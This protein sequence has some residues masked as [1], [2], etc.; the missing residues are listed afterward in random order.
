MP[1]SLAFRPKRKTPLVYQI[2]R[3]LSSHP[4][5]GT[6]RHRR[7]PK[8]KRPS[9]QGQTAGGG[10]G[11]VPAPMHLSAFFRSSRLR[12]A[13]FF[14][15]IRNVLND[16]INGAG[17][18]T[19]LSSGDWSAAVLVAGAVTLLLTLWPYPLPHV[20]VWDDLAVAAGLR[21][22][23]MEFPGL[24][25]FL[26]RIL[27]DRLG[28]DGGMAAMAVG[29]HLLAGFTAGLWYF[30]FRQ[31]LEFGGRLDMADHMWNDKLAPALSAAGALLVAFAEPVWTASQTFTAAGLDLFL[32]AFALATLFRFIARGR[33]QM[34]VLAFLTLGMLAAETPFGLLP[35]V[36][37]AVLFFLSWRM[38]DTHDDIEPVVR[39]PPLEEFPWLLIA[40]AWVIGA[41]L[42]LAVTDS[43][44]RAAGGDPGEFD[45]ALAAWRGLWA[46][47][48]TTKGLLSG[49]GMT[50]APLAFLTAIFPRV[51]FP[52]GRKPLWLRL[53]VLAAGLMALTQLTDIPALRYRTWTG[54][55]EEVARALLPGL[56]TAAAG[57]AAVMAAAAFAAMAW[58]HETRCPWP[59]LMLGRVAVGAVV[60]AAVLTACNGRQCRELRQKLQ[61][62]ETHIRRTLDD[63]KGSDRITSHG[64]LDVMLELRA[65]SQGRQLTIV[66]EGE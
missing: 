10:R 27:F 1:Y 41:G 51:T 65:K 30:V 29:G 22:P 13:A 4:R 17:M 35:L 38:I 14:G 3:P 7:P 21:T 59:V 12:R 11:D 34:G 2:R 28:T 9:A 37:V 44:F 16:S 47:G 60:A 5:N 32:A 6:G 46:E 48:T 18:R 40:L 52:V 55:D 19:R 23:T 58:C 66:K 31:L 57:A 45:S 33:R 53:A 49:A 15:I 64:R 36:P 61:K 42:T 20:C 8:G 43:A 62:V 54:E 63:C 26:A 25:P 24:A 56:F 39:L 50:V